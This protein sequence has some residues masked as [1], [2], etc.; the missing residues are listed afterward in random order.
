MLT[1]RIGY[2]QN[3]GKPTAF[4]LQTFRPSLDPK[5]GFQTQSGVSFGQWNFNLATNFG[6]TYDSL[7]LIAEGRKGQIDVV[8]TQVS[9][10][11]SVGLGLLNWLDLEL[12]LPVTLYQSGKLPFLDV[13]GDSKGQSLSRGFAL[14]D[15]SIGVRGQFLSEKSTG[16]DLGLY[17]DLRL[18]T[19]DE[20][21]FN[22]EEGVSFSALLLFGK[23]FGPVRLSA[24]FGYSYQSP[25]EFLG[26]VI[27]HELNY[28][29][30]GSLALLNKKL[31]II[32]DFF[33][34]VGLSKTSISNSPLS[35]LTGVRF[36]P[37]ETI[38]LDLGVG[39]GIIG[40]IGSPKFRGTFSFGW[41]PS[42]GGKK[43]SKR[44]AEPI[45][46]VSDRD[47][48]GIPDDRDRCPD[49][50][51]PKHSEGCPV[52][53]D[54]DGIPDSL[55]RCPKAPGPRESD[56]CPKDSDGDGIPDSKDRCPQSPGSP[57]S[58]GCPKDSDGDGVPDNQDQCPQKAGSP[59]NRGCPEKKE[60]PDRDGDRVP[61]ARD[62]CPDIPGSR[63]RRGCPRRVYAV[64]RLKK[65]KIYLTKHLLFRRGWRPKKR[66]RVM[67]WQ[68]ASILKSRPE[69]EKVRVEVITY[70]RRRTRRLKRLAR[71]RAKAVKRYLLK[72]RVAPERFK[73]DWKLKRR[74]R[75]RRVRTVAIVFIER[76]AN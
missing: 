47:S 45:A 54:G 14:R 50:F 33:G 66:T 28:S 27:G 59:E 39:L 56:G 40:G 67:L 61:N 49:L 52:D 25:T 20:S 65:G 64:L 7:F 32:L 68:L 76:M 18:P 21:S 9:W 69:I 38:F 53:S 11:L 24:N 41:I 63:R 29:I 4:Q 13:L 1:P 60:N 15:L 23:E 55:D 10:D 5:G 36:F 17:L 2:T 71:L 57:D 75:A 72:Y 70:S 16:V 35:F 51:G 34:K 43:K 48:D 26:A 31:L 42:F 58:D 37:A 3:A 74:R 30:A 46:R 12:R 6:F 73:V 62:R 22:G 8:K 19:G 44:S